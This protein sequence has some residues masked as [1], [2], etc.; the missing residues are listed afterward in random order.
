MKLDQ[1]TLAFLQKTVETISVAKINNLVI[2]PGRIRAMEE[3]RAVLVF[4]NTD[5]PNMPFGS[6]GISEASTF[7][8]RFEIVKSVS[9]VD[10]E[11]IMDNTNTFVRSLEMRGKGIKI[12]FRCANPA[13][14]R[15]PKSMNDPIKYKI[16]MTPDAVT[17]MTK[18]AT[19][20]STD[21]VTIKGSAENVSLVFE[22][23]NRDAME[24]QFGTHMELVDPSTADVN[25]SFDRTYP[26]KILLPLLKQNPGNCL[27]ITHAGFIKLSINGLDMYVPPRI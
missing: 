26:V 23:A 10:V 1:Q 9:N 20:L 4:Q 17:L 24:Y 19:A 18:G 21:E 14:I 15:A 16:Q 11:A 8:S 7:I 12:D 25:S 5:V 3:N 22:D 2:E 6:I 13:T 27:Y